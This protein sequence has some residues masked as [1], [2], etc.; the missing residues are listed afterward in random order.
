[1]LPSRACFT[2]DTASA[3]SP[4]STVELFHSGLSSVDDTTYF[5]MLLNL[6][7]NSPSLDG[8]ASANPA[9]VTRPSSK[10]SESSVSSSLNL[11][12]SSPRSN[13]KVHPL[14]LKS[15]APPGS[16]ITPSS[17]TNSVTTILPIS[18]SSLVWGN[19]RQR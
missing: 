4:S 9:Y 18:V 19:G 11:F 17:E 3:T 2:S 6:S 1:M 14:Y 16:S 7:A 15:S 13:S 10:A 12:P 8:H 5:G